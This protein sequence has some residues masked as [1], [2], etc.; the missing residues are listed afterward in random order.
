MNFYFIEQ[1]ET[2]SLLVYI[3]KFHTH[4]VMKLWKI[5]TMHTSASTANVKLMFFSF[6]L[7]PPHNVLHQQSN[8]FPW[9]VLISRFH[10]ARC[11]GCQSL[12]ENQ[13]NLNHGAY[14]GCKTR[15]AEF[16]DFGARI[17]REEGGGE[18]GKEVKFLSAC[19]VICLLLWRRKKKKHHHNGAWVMASWFYALSAECDFFFFLPQTKISIFFF[20]FFW[21]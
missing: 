4:R 6:Y 20:F 8:L 5:K 19:S 17:K 16:S 9:S 21:H 11:Y 2:C 13:Q 7:P 14:P 18:S 10:S 15:P 3:K 1:R 12:H